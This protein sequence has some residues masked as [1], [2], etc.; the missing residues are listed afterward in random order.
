MKRESRGRGRRHGPG[1]HGFC[2]PV[3]QGV[4]LLEPGHTKDHSLRA[5]RGDEEGVLVG[6][7]S[8]GIR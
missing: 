8:D 1:F 5:D 7:T 6:N 4:N 2:N 3:D